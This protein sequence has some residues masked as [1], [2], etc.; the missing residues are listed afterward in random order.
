MDQI[1]KGGFP[2][3]RLLWHSFE[4]TLTQFFIQLWHD[5]DTIL[6]LLWQ[7]FGTALRQFRQ[8]LDII[9]T[10]H[11]VYVE[12]GHRLLSLRSKRDPSK[13]NWLNW[14]Q[15]LYV[16]L[17]TRIKYSYELNDQLKFL[18]MYEN[19]D[20]YFVHRFKYDDAQYQIAL[21]WCWWLQWWKHDDFE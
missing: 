20:I 8:S 3:D 16:F 18:K 13:I 6:T 11:K 19:I 4:I 2:S 12:K 15:P 7:N 5:S 14:L 1:S 9:L 17:L 21:F 10:H